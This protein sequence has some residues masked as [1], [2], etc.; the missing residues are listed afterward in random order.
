MNKWY[1]KTV[2]KAVVLFLAILSG[3]LLVTNLFSFLTLAGGM[4]LSQIRK[5]NTQSFEDSEEFTAMVENYMYNVQEKIQLEHLFENDGSYNPQ[6]VIDVMELSKQG[7]AS[8]ENTSGVAY[9]LEELVNWGEAYQGTDTENLY[10]QNGVIV[11]QKPDGN[12]YYY[13][14]NE[15]FSLIDAGKLRL[16]MDE[17]DKVQFLKGLEEGD[18]TSSGYYTFQIT[19]ESGNLLYTDCW[20]FG[21]S[22]IEKYAPVGADNLL[23][24]VNNNQQL[25]GR[26][27][28][29]Y[30]DIASV[31][32]TI[33]TDMQSYEDGWDYLEEGN[34]NFA[35]LYVDEDTKKVITNKK[36]YANYADVEKNIEAMTASTAKNPVKYMV[37]YPKLGDFK[38]N[39]NVSHS[40]QWINTR[41][42]SA[43][44]GGEKWKDIFAVAVDTNYPIQDQFYQNSVAY[45]DNIPHVKTTMHLLVFSSILFLITVVWL[46]LEA[47]RKETDGDLH[48][49][50]FDSWKTEIGAVSAI[51]PWIFGTFFFFAVGIDMIS[52]LLDGYSGMQ[53]THSYMESNSFIASSYVPS[54]YVQSLNLGET[55]GIF[56]YGVFT[57]A[58]FFGGYLSLV[59]RI[60]AKS[61]WKNSLLRDFCEVVRKVVQNLRLTRKTAA[62]LIAYFLFQLFVV[63]ERN[64]FLIVLLLLADAV[65]FYSMLTNVMEKNRLK[66]GIEE[67]ASGNMGYQIQMKG[68]RGENKKLA[69][70]I[71]GIGTGLNKAVAEAMKNERLKTDLITN[72]SHD[73]KTPLTSILNYVGILRQTDPS[74][75]KVQDYLD[76][77]EKKAQRLKTLTEDVVEA[78]KVSSGNISLEYMDIDLVEMIQQTQGELAE[79][80][81]ARNL[82]IVLEIPQEPAVVHVDGRRMWRVLE[83]IFGNAAKYAMPGTRVYATLKADETKVSFSLKNV[84]EHQLNIRADE[85]TE[86]F[87][88]GD[89]SRSTEGSGLGLSI[90]KSLTTMQGGT[91]DLYLDGDLFRVDITFPGVKNLRTEE[92]ATNSESEESEKE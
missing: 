41:A 44:A 56:G 26:L 14:T 31:L 61:L 30:D 55:V 71:N 22:M 39:M 70:M 83:N 63:L 84:S 86:R 36:E 49:L 40:D 72:V 48:L 64:F 5:L 12:Y 1:R 25:N 27:T 52:V 75:P 82:T 18:F 88:R 80:F 77:L 65:L 11:C 38:T 8:G 35:Y 79:K 81:E 91:F 43:H 62:L 24:I 32:D 66:K 76:I 87:I 54:M 45:Q 9:T 90:A 69:E 53:T 6:K 78:S 23:Q 47:G 28:I 68:L 92:S 59:R 67:I 57:F 15:F 73:I 58:C 51:L 19:D 29:V 10:N 3:A 2:T 50:K 13:Y 21:Q 17:N 16:E 89:I 46:T 33:Y 37:V 34:T 85:L 7:T 74:D 42:Y 4:S 20:N 60:K